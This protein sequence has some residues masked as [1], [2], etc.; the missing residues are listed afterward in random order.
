MPGSSINSPDA[1]IEMESYHP[2]PVA[3]AKSMVFVDAASR[4]LL[5]LLERVAPSEAAILIGGETGTGKELVARH[6]HHFSGRRGPF[7]PVN[8]GAITETLAESEF[9]G[10]EAGSFTGAIGRREGWFEAANHGTLFL[11][12]LGELPAALQA[13]LLR[14][15][16]EREVVRIGS[17]KPI[18]IDVRIVSATNV[19]LAQAVAAGRFRLDLFYR[20]NIVQVKLPPLRERT[21]DIGALA[22]HF[23]RTY[24]KRLELPRPRLSDEAFQA[25]MAY[26]WPGN[27][28]ELENVIHFA[29][30]IANDEI[31]P[32][33]LR[34]DANALEPQLHSASAAIE[35]ASGPLQ[36]VSKALHSMFKAPGDRL[37]NH[38]ERHVVEEAYRHCG[39]NQV[40]AA[41]LLGISRNVLRTLLRKHGLLSTREQILSDAA[42]NLTGDALKG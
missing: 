42:D 5:D 6:I 33:H 29:L 19:D 36:S 41:A 17:R 32:I 38:L 13:K 31:H 20:L 35:Q 24:S 39:S 11:D 28:R 9:F 12:E 10:H 14:V 37:F 4:E 22:E 3:R 15:L 8:C 40:R 30:L 7:I 21:G 23:I 34:L 2:N 26:H 18:P 1:V 16:Q 25:L 27:I